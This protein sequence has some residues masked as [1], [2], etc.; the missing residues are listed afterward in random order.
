MKHCSYIYAVSFWVVFL[1][2]FSSF[3]S[4]Q[5]RPVRCEYEMRMEIP[6]GVLEAQQDPAV[7]EIIRKQYEETTR[8]YVLACADGKYLFHCIREH[9]ELS[10]V[11]A[12]RTLY[13]DA[14]RDLAV[15]V[16]KAERLYLIEDTIPRHRWTITQ[17]SREIVGYPCTKAV[18]DGAVEAW[19]TFD[20][21]FSFGPLGYNGLPG[22]VVS[23]K[24]GPNVYTVSNLT[25]PD[26]LQIE[27][28]TE[29][30]K[31]TRER[32]NR[33]VE[34]ALHPFGL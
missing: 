11:G 2:L 19:F 10:E 16:E 7:R 24:R 6:K 17:E 26:S 29:G 15:S 13:E 9:E 27:K 25:F 3:L 12:V 33:I 21:P 18:T 23:L 5:S 8:T 34:R 14:S 30:K 1:C 32:F 4:A 22:L 31:I 28:P 20:I